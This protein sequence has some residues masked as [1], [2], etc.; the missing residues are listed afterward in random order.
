MGMDEIIPN[1]WIGDLQAAQDVE[2]LKSNGI[3]SVLSAMRGRVRINEVIGI[4][5]LAEHRSESIA[6]IYKAPDPP[7]RYIGHRRLGTFSSCHCLHTSGARGKEE[8]CPSALPGR[9]EC[10][11]HCVGCIHD[12]DQ[13]IGR[14][15]T[16]VAAYLMYTSKL[17]PEEAISMIREKRP[18]IECGIFSSNLFNC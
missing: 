17:S 18:I 5:G 6:D 9:N 2:T 8:R 11:I 4:I 16:I 3:F 7:R 12:I 15:A 1:L 13:A 10:V 14:S